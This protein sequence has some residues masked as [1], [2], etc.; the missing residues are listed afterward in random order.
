MLSITRSRLAGRKMVTHRIILVTILTRHATPNKVVVVIAAFSHGGPSTNHVTSMP[1]IKDFQA[2]VPNLSEKQYEDIFSVLNSK[3]DGP[4]AKNDGP[5]AH[6][7]AFIS[8]PSGLSLL[9][10]G[11]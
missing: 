3:N 9:V 2:D 11:Q 10:P 5:Q 6:A 1:T 7:A 4:P 8:Q